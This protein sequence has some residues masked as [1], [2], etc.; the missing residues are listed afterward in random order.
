MSK[1]QS[2][3]GKRSR[4][5]RVV[6]LRHSLAFADYQSS[7]R[8]VVIRQL[9][10]GAIT[11]LEIRED[12][13]GLMIQMVELADDSRACDQIRGAVSGNIQ[14]VMWHFDVTAN[15]AEMMVTSVE[16]VFPEM[17]VKAREPELAMVG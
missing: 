8:W 14:A 7:V 3:K 10:E 2:T 16:T 9:R 6:R 1:K 12:I 4:F 11:L 13:Q 5:E 15:E 17:V